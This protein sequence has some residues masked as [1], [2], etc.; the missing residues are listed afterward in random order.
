[1]E[2]DELSELVKDARS[3]RRFK[4]NQT[5]PP[6]ELEKVIDTVRHVS[7]PLNKQPIRYA[8][9]STKENVDALSEKVQWAAHLPDWD[10][11]LDE[12]PTAYIIMINDTRIDGFEMLDAGICLQTMVLLLK[13]KGYSSCPLASIDKPQCKAMLALEPHYEPMLGIAI[14]ISSEITKTVA[15]EDDNIGYY[16]NESDEHCVPKRALSEV[17]LGVA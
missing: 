4:Q 11:S 2:F 6:A 3:V 8:I 15:I 16:R 10:Q 7:S 9:I 12:R 5:I 17:L 14:G 1:M 13:S